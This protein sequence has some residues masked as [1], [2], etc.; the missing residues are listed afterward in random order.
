MLRYF[1]TSELRDLKPEH[2]FRESRWYHA[3]WPIALFITGCVI[4]GLLIQG[5]AHEV[6]WWPAVF[7]FVFSALTMIANAPVFLPSNWLMKTTSDGM[8]VKF[9]SY[10][11]YKLPEHHETVVFIPYELIFEAR[12]VVERRVIIMPPNGKQI[13]K[14]RHIDI[15]L[16]TADSGRLLDLLKAEREYEP[17]SGLRRPGKVE[18]YP[19]TIPE[20]G[21]IRLTWQAHETAIQPKIGHALMVL[22]E[23]VP[24]GER[25]HAVNEYA[26]K[27]RHDELE[28]RLEK[29]CREG[30]TMAAVTVARE[31]YGFPLA[32]A[33][34]YVED[35]M[36]KY[37]NEDTA[38]PRKT[39]GRN[40]R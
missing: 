32:E 36:R 29:L 25:Q 14:V 38:N 11:N 28:A 10:L 22:S 37:R 18:A 33:T 12:E 5:M 9:R 23:H 16:R 34:L 40:S 19:V 21:V 3:G 26:N 13:T 7:C 2:T 27:E 4:V 31:R 17:E 39:A 24:I 8:Y 30:R 35:M 6:M 20:P 1:Q 15:L